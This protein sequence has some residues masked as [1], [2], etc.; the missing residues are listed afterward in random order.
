MV[1]ISR[2]EDRPGLGQL[3]EQQLVSSGGPSP[4]DHHGAIAEHVV[5]VTL[6]MTVL[7]FFNA[8]KVAR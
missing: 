3:H 1:Q 6:M 5:V 2:E 7:L 4:L 8:S